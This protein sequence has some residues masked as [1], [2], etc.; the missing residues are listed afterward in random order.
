MSFSP[1]LFSITS[2]LTV[3]SIFVLQDNKKLLQQSAIAEGDATKDWTQEELDSFIAQ[4]DWT[5]VSKYIA[6]MRSNKTAKGMANR[7]RS[8]PSTL[9]KQG[10]IENNRRVSSSKFGAKSQIQPDELSVE[11]PVESESLWNSLSSRSRESSFEEEEGSSYY[12]E[13]PMMSKRSSKR[14]A[15][16]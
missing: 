2:H 6:E 3:R 8:E 9:E 14:Q 7:T 1:S 12:E 11:S 10:R 4:N 13:T 16:L 15:L 5:S